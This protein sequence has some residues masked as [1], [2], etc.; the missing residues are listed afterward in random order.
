M[1]INAAILKWL[2]DKTLEEFLIDCLTYFGF[3][4]GTFV[5]LV[6]K[7]SH[8]ECVIKNLYFVCKVSLVYITY[9]LCQDIYRI[10][11]AIQI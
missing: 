10:R 5:Q 1:F 2:M 7:A 8:I 3:R 6:E 4:D 9:Y 11:V